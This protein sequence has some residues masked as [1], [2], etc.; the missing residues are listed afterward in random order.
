[1]IKLAN[2]LESMLAK[3]T[4]DKSSG[5]MKRHGPRLLGGLLGGSTGG[6][7]MATS[8]NAD[9]TPLGVGG[10]YIAGSLLGHL[11]TPNS[12]RGFD[13]EEQEE[14]DKKNKKIGR[15]PSDQSK[16]DSTNKESRKKATMIKIA[17]NLTVL[18]SNK[19]AE[20]RGN[21]VV[22][23]DTIGGGI[24]DYLTNPMGGLGVWGARR[25]ARSSALGDSVGVDPGLLL[26]HPGKSRLLATLGGALLGGGLGA[27]VGAIDAPE[28]AGALG[29]LG[30]LGG[31]LGG[32]LYASY[33]QR[34]KMREINK[35]VDEAETLNPIQE[36]GLGIGI[37]GGPYNLGRVQAEQILNSGGDSKNEVLR[38]L[39][40][41][42]NSQDTLGPLVANIIPGGYFPHGINHD[43]SARKLRREGGKKRQNKETD[44]S[45]KAENTYTYDGATEAGKIPA[46]VMLALL[47][48]GVG[49]AGGYLGSEDK[50]KKRNAILA[51]ILGAGAGGAAG[52]YGADLSSGV[53]G[54]N[55]K[56][57]PTAEGN[58]VGNMAPGFAKSYAT[59][60]NDI[61]S[62]GNRKTPLSIGQ[63]ALG[64]KNYAQDKLHT[65]LEGLPLQPKSV[66]GPLGIDMNDPA[67]GYR[68]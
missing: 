15:K 52:Y 32:S 31:G 42:S 25:A 23:M 33:L 14:Q 8:G 13:K 9:L 66:R 50:N 48:G 46:A 47:G 4:Y 57:D 7:A 44:S 62:S 37:S 26:K 1:M 16:E 43:L 34:E 12:W 3:Q 58:F 19:F 22:N 28:T 35:A 11:L 54:R 41:S 55:T 53:K 68:Q 30:G 17:N 27:G 51:G 39:V 60:M 64:L 18:C 10:G 2:N 63:L 61:N 5:F 36:Q 20:V 45:K 29:I 21:D 6:V 59:L 49:A 38:N 65:G 24:A 40:D 67:A 56:V